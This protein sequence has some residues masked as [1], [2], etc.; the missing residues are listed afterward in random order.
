MSLTHTE[1]EEI[2]P[3]HGGIIYGHSL[4]YKEY[5]LF[6]TEKITRYQLEGIE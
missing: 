2:L 5:L 1:K 3:F 6:F 4:I